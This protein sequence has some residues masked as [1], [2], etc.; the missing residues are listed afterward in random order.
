M[1]LKEDT[2]YGGDLLASMGHWRNR[3]WRDKSWATPTAELPADV[4]K[5]FD[6]WRRRSF[7]GISRSVEA[8]PTEARQQVAYRWQTL[9]NAAV[10]KRYE[11]A[12][13]IETPPKNEELKGV[14][15]AAQKSQHQIWLDIVSDS[16]IYDELVSRAEKSD[17]GHE[18][19][20]ALKDGRHN[21]ARVF[22]QLS[23]GLARL[24]Y[25]QVA[26]AQNAHLIRWHAL[27]RESMAVVFQFLRS[28]SISATDSAQLL[29]DRE[30]DLRKRF[31]LSARM[32]AS[33][34]EEFFINIPVVISQFIGGGGTMLWRRELW[35]KKLG[36]FHDS[37]PAWRANSLGAFFSGPD[38]RELF[39]RFYPVTGVGSFSGRAPA[40]AVYLHVL[41]EEVLAALVA[42]SNNTSKTLHD[43][44]AS[45]ISHGLLRCICLAGRSPGYTV[46]FGDVTD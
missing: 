6:E 30:D 8:A 44:D 27:A 46:T 31:R 10:K 11:E 17:L 9:L 45:S 34:E 26:R 13:K 5:R 1:D 38:G 12:I 15:W 37:R 33:L 19:L 24:D 20:T 29:A 14:N 28:V 3:L 35:D 21:L 42:A 18:F 22:P 43:E 25:E 16:Q 2:P 36:A 40:E 23:V 7:E 32:T 4:Q 41:G 39:V